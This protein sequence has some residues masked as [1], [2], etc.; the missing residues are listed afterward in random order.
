MGLVVDTSA[1][2]AAERGHVS[3]SALDQEILGEATVLAAAAYAEILVGV[4]RADTPTRA[5]D[6][7]RRFDALVGRVP[8]VP[9]GEPEARRWARLFSHFQDSGRPLP[10]NDLA[11]A[12]TA[13]EL[14]F[15]VLV[16]PQRERHFTL[17]PDLRVVTLASG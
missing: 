4:H 10:A 9:F 1:V 16:G 11:I 7:Q 12:A 15:G 14:G 6:R 3:W 8:V 2:V 13:L 17:V 5:A